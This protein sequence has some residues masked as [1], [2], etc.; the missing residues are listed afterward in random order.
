MGCRVTLLAL[1]MGS[2][3]PTVPVD[4]VDPP[5]LVDRLLTYTDWFKSNSWADTRGVTG[6][7]PLHLPYGAPEGFRMRFPV[8]AG[9]I[10]RAR[11]EDGP[12][13]TWAGATTLTATADG[14]AW[15]DPINTAFPADAAPTLRTY[16]NSTTGAVYTTI[17]GYDAR[18]TAWLFG[19]TYAS[20]GVTAG[21]TP[22]GGPMAVPDAVVG[23]CDDTRP[24]VL[25]VGDSITAGNKSYVELA[26]RAAGIPGRNVGTGGEHAVTFLGTIDSKNAGLDYAWFTHC[27]H[28]H[29]INDTSSVTWQTVASR[30]ITNWEWSAAK[31]YTNVQLTGLPATSSTDGHTTI[32]GQTPFSNMW[33]GL[34]GANAWL[35]DGAPILADGTP[36]DPGTAAAIASRAGDPD[37]PLNLIWDTAQ[38]AYPAGHID[39]WKAPGWGG[40]GVHPT[41]TA[42]AGLA[43][44]AAG[45]MQSLL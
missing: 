21:M 39:R 28:Q 25:Q 11:L 30:R 42:H 6:R 36:A 27:I 38:H 9:Q 15:T 18:V 41:A 13:F 14:Y 2:T 4:P 34:S 37:H 20:N 45:Y 29:L 12:E 32:E 16:T 23:P 22:S 7:G 3:G 1:L 8:K 26:A 35:R 43:P 19:D 44:V 40:D 33:P 24:V 5:T 17:G 10:I 31:G